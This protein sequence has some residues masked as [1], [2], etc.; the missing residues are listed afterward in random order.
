M[1]EFGRV[2]DGC[3]GQYHALGLGFQQAAGLVQ[4]AGEPLG[5][6]IE[7]VAP[8]GEGACAQGG[9][10][11]LVRADDLFRGRSELAGSGNRGPVFV[12]QVVPHMRGGEF[13]IAG[14]EGGAEVALQ[15]AERDA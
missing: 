14:L 8:V 15:L 6:G 7:Q 4:R 13:V 11:F 3:A 9:E 12:A 2:V 5:H 1:L 10:D